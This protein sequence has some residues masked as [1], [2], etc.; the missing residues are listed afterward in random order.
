LAYFWFTIG[1]SYGMWLAYSSP[2]DL[3]LPKDSWVCARDHK[4]EGCLMWVRKV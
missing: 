2:S 4:Q 1:A 3:H